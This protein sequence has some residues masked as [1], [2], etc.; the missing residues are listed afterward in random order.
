MESVKWMQ[1]CWC[2][3]AVI[4]IL[5]INVKTFALY[6]DKEMDKVSGVELCI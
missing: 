4:L 5:N 6:N 3:A 2:S 1:M